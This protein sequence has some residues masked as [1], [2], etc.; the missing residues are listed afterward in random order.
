LIS[1]FRA[2]STLRGPGLDLTRRAWRSR[3]AIDVSGARGS[4]M[5]R[6]GLRLK[7]GLILIKSAPHG[8]P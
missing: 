5:R 2:D 4:H 7:P 1:L 8:S 6:I 3:N